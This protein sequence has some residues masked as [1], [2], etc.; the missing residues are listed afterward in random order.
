V[1]AYLGQIQWGSFF[2]LLGCILSF[3][4]LYSVFAILVEV[5]TFNQ[6]KGKYDIFKLFLAAFLEPFIFHPYIV[7]SAIRGNLDYIRKKNNWGEMTRRGLNPSK[8]AASV[9]IS[10]LTK[11]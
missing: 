3:G 5:L 4:F 8:P 2:I 10:H 6:Y 7:W 11:P 1:F 9:S